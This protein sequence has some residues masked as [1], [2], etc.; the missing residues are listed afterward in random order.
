[1]GPPHAW[2]YLKLPKTTHGDS[3]MKDPP[4]F[5]PLVSHTHTQTGRELTFTFWD[6]SS[7]A[8]PECS[9]SLSQLYSPTLRSLASPASFGGAG[10]AFPKKT[11]LVCSHS[12]FTLRFFEK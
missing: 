6:P 7:C 8:L 1:M 9:K 4:P 2:N 12:V 11:R 10:L 5:H 3:F